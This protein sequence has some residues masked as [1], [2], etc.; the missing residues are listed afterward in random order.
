MSASLEGL[1]ALS[2]YRRLLQINDPEGLDGTLRVVR[3]GAGDASALSLST[4]GA[5]IVGDLTV[6][7]TA[8][9]P[10]LPLGTGAV[11]RT[12]QDWM[13]DTPTV[14]DFGAVGDG[15]ANDTTALENAFAAAVTTGSRVVLFPA[16]RYYITRDLEVPTGV[17]LVALTSSWSYD[18]PTQ[19][20]AVLIIGYA[21]FTVIPSAARGL[22]NMGRSTSLMNIAVAGVPDRPAIK[23][24]EQ[25]ATFDKVRTF[26]G[27]IGLDLTGSLAPMVYN[28]SHQYSGAFSSAW[29]TGQ[30][31]TVGTL[32]QNAGQAYRA[33]TA[34]TTGATAPTHTS[35]TVS[36]GAVSW[37]WIYTVNATIAAW[38]AGQTIAIGDLRQNLGRAY[39]AT[40][41]GTTGASA[42]THATGSASDGGVTWAYYSAATGVVS[43][44]NSGGL[45]S[46]YGASDAVVSNPI[47]NANPYRGINVAS[48]TKYTLTN[49]TL[50]WNGTNG[51]AF[52]NVKHFNMSGHQCDRNSGEGLSFQFLEKFSIANGSMRRSAVGYTNC[53]M[54]LSGP[55][56]DGVFNGNSYGPYGPSDD[57]SW[58]TDYQVDGS[59][60]TSFAVSFSF[61]AASEILVLLNGA[62]LTLTTD[63]TVSGSNVILNTGVTR[64]FVNV[65]RASSITP[66]YVYSAAA[67]AFANVKFRETPRAQKTDIYADAGT[68]AAISPLV[69]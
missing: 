5:S 47:C 39:R 51:G 60:R 31:V 20:P 55:I 43:A 61:S 57:T 65:W 12:I 46:L 14:K 23:C 8:S 52:Y 59:S 37:L 48:S 3:D 11:S 42:P 63:Y 41:A 21:G 45:V 1:R 68:S 16:G 40:T 13:R 44:A 30:L 17:S 62:A 25:W 4:G 15:T 9:I 6:N 22:I 53:H 49:P 67:A 54:I 28:T 18:Y 56:L 7:G 29:V 2:T 64:A 33:T 26:G 58:G 69:S 50:E 27:S 35:G 19:L 10:Y 36:D 38:A 32:R 66:A 34:G 24:S